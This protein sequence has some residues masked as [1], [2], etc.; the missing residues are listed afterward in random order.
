MLRTQ[1]KGVFLVSNLLL[2]PLEIIMFEII[3]LSGSDVSYDVTIAM[4]VAQ[5]HSN[6]DLGWVSLFVSER[7]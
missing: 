6:P 5:R 2:C 3:F 7:D 1:L 4:D